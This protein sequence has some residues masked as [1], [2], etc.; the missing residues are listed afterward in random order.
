VVDV[1]GYLEKRKNNLE[2]MASSMAEKARRTKK[3]VT[4]GQMNAHDQK[5]CSYPS[6]RC[7]WCEDTEHRRRLF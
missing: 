4:I 3:S 7:E 1:E 6:E 5:N 2:E